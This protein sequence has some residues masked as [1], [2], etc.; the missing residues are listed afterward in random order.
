M[1]PIILA[2]AFVAALVLAA[3]VS[4]RRR[5]APVVPWPRVDATRVAAPAAKPALVDAEPPR[6]RAAVL[7]EAVPTAATIS[8]KVVAP[9]LPQP[10]LVPPPAVRST[11]DALDTLDA[12]LAELESTTVRI[13]GADELD[14]GSVAALEGLADRLEAAAASLGTR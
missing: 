2:V 8:G 4:R 7:T 12:L 14:E 3:L 9:A 11:E 6:Q 1:L 13:D 10:V 5:Q